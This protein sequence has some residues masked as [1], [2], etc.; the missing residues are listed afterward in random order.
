MKKPGGFIFGAISVFFVSVLLSGVASASD[1]QYDVTVTNL[2]RSEVF[3]PIMVTTH[4][5]HNKM[6]MLGNE[7]SDGL[8]AMA[9]GGDTQALSASLKPYDSQSSG[10]LL[11]PGESVTIRIKAKKKHHI[12]V[13]SMLVPTNDAFFAVNGIKLPKNHHSM[14]IMSPAYDAGSEPN[15]ELCANMPGPFCKGV[16]GTPDVGGEN[17]VHIH[18]GIHGMGDLLAA[19]FDW[20]NPVAKI[21]IRQVKD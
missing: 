19:D 3:T 2:T 13:A 15:D 20:R 21:S 5:G 8:A 11:Q 1:R 12:S 10:A 14:T 7:A 4:H 6:F 17:Y 9:E 16:G 18:S